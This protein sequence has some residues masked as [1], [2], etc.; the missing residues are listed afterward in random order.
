[1]QH[2]YLKLPL[3]FVKLW[4]HNEYIHCLIIL[5]YLWQVRLFD[6]VDYLKAMG[7]G[8]VWVAVGWS[9]DVIPFSKRTSNI[10][11]FAP[12]SGTSLWADLWVSFF[13]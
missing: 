5:D 12:E 6:D 11:V 13:H 9:S 1:M 2:G 3:K 10:S 7:A 8:D 4:D